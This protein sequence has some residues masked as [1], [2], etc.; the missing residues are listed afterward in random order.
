MKLLKQ[1]ITMLGVVAVIT[2]PCLAQQ[3][4]DKQGVVKT[5]ELYQAN[6][7]FLNTTLYHSLNLLKIRKYLREKND[8]TGI[9]KLVDY[10]LLHDL[11]IYTVKQNFGEQYKDKTVLGL[12]SKN[13][14]LVMQEFCAYPPKYLGSY[15]KPFE[16]VKNDCKKENCS[17][18]NILEDK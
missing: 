3:Q 8:F 15:S 14:K 13:I 5:E 18:C 12:Y 11:S 17:E 4:L 16:V 2:T 10:A 6:V 1:V 9:D 7:S